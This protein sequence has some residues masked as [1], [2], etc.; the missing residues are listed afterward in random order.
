ML[1]SALKV[2]PYIQPLLYRCEGSSIHTTVA[3]QVCDIKAPVFRALLHFVYT[4]SLPEEHD[5]ASLDVAMAQHLLVAADQYQL[6]RL[7]R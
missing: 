1:R 4:D 7:R 5:A 3:I 6:V 2:L